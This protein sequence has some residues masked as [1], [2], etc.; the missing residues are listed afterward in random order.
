MHDLVVAATEPTRAVLRAITD[1][2]LAARTPCADF[3]VRALLTHLLTWGPTLVGSAY[4][5]SVPPADS[6]T[7][8]WRDGLEHHLDQ[9]V[10]GWSR[11]EA[12]RGTTPMATIELPAATVGGMVVGELVV[13]GWDL[14]RATDRWPDWPEALL[15]PLHEEI[16]RTAAQGREMHVYGPEVPVSAGATTLDRLLGVTGRDPQWKP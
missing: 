1:D 8:D 10:A 16:A 12:W 5:R 3:D 6:V 4:G 2:Q 11:P 7:G 14:A 13:H 9:V 15:G